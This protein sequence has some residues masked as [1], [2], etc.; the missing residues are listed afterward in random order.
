MMFY[1]EDDVIGGKSSGVS[2]IGDKVITLNW[3]MV[4]R[5]SL[6]EP[7]LFCVFVDTTGIV[8]VVPAVDGD[9]PANCPPQTPRPRPMAEE[10][11]V[12]HGFAGYRVWVREVWRLDK[13]ELARQ[14][15]WGQDSVSAA[16]YWSFDKHYNDSI[17]TYA[18]EPVQNA[19]PYEFSVTAIMSEETEDTARDTVEV[20]YELMC[21]EG[22]KTG[23]VYPLGGVQDN[24]ASI[25]AIPNPYR[26]GADWEY[27]D[28]PQRITFI[29]LPGKATIRIYTAAADHVRTLIHENPESDQEFWNLRNEDGD[30]VA[31][32]VYIWAVE[33]GTT[34][35]Q[36]RLLIIK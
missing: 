2:V 30:E 32:G 7:L 18:V 11:L 4:H 9:C 3:A 31:P 22:N 10:D 25:Q 28:D 12:E 36:G 15:D 8:T 33:S 6:G 20:D 17:R 23:I 26:A 24:L 35:A 14:F 1:D 13:F 19:F 27:T 29:G 16:G 5:D 34:T 21:L